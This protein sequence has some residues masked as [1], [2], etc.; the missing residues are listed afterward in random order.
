MIGFYVLIGIISLCSWLVSS[1]LKRKF[2]KYSQVHLKNGMSGAE[3][4][5][6]MLNDHGINDVKVIS[7]PGMLTDHY[8]PQNKT[9]NLS[10]GVYNQRNAASAAVA[11]H[12]VGHAVQHAR[13]YEYLQMRSKLVPMV[14][15]T[16]K[17]S[18]W[19]VIG[20]I[21]F[22]AASGNSGIGFYI[23]IAGLIFM[24]VGTLFS[25]VTLPVEYDASNRALAWLEDK[26]IV[27][28]EEL[29]GSKDALKW[30]AR[31]YLVAALGSLAMLLYWGMRILGNRD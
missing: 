9:V 20:G 7:T 23:A 5:Q 11:A 22:G 29:A 30:A 14:S 13:A 16:S 18:Q 31:T 3:I 8:N 4:A 1:M 24:A 12:E 6:K 10:E 28:R 26:H 2:K 15:I 27:T 21:T 19:M 17:Y 25:F